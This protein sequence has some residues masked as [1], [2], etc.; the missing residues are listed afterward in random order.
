MPL[1]VAGDSAGGN[2]AAIVAQRAQAEGGPEIAL[3]VLVYPVTDADV[4]NGEL[5]R[6]GQPAAAH[7]ASR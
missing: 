2:L 3:Q 5:R 4:D 6:P 7:A 1:I